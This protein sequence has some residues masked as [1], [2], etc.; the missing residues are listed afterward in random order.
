MA[1][2]VAVAI[3]S[4]STSTSTT[5]NNHEIGANNGMIRR[6]LPRWINLLLN[7]ETVENEG[8]AIDIDIAAIVVAGSDAALGMIFSGVH[9]RSIRISMRC[10]RGGVPDHRARHLDVAHR[11]RR[12]VNLFVVGDAMIHGDGFGGNIVMVGRRRRRRRLLQ[13]QWLDDIPSS[14]RGFA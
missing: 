8:G 11:L 5:R 1:I 7:H 12:L 9:A 6:C 4:T 3:A 14:K 13:H 10:S 2:G